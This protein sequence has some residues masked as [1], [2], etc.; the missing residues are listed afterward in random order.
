MNN[1][2]K[3]EKMMSFWS[4]RAKLY[5]DDARTNT[6]DIWLRELEINYVDRILK[7]Y[8][9]K[10]ALDFGCANGYSLMKIAKNNKNINFLG[11][12]INQEMIDIAFESLKKNGLKNIDFLKLDI[13]ENKLNEKYDLIFA[14]RVFQN[15]ESHEMQKK[16]FDELCRYLSR[17]GMILFIESYRKGYERLN[18]DRIKIGLKPLPIHEHLTLLDEKFDNFVSKKSTILQSSFL[19]SSYYLI[20]RLLYSY[21]AKMENEPIDYNHPIHRISSLVPQIGD[22]GPQKATLLQLVH[23]D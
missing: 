4:E 11:I 3:R 19:S 22:Y 23:T 21:L 14:I 5:K 10:R 8:P 1:G 7:S 9:I 16:V 17:N 13:M 12:D 15:I 18:R 6:N 2:K 20:T